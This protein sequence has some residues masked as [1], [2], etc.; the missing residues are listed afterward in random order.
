MILCGA[1]I[2]AA[3]TGKSEDRTVALGTLVLTAVWWV[4]WLSAAAATSSTTQWANS[5]R[6]AGGWDCGRSSE[7][8]NSLAANGFSYVNVYCNAYDRVPVL[9]ACCAFC[10]LTWAL[11]SGSLFFCIKEDVMGKRVLGGGAADAAPAAGTPA[12]AAPAAAPA[13]PKQVDAV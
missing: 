5:W 1:F 11:W 3:L 8:A 7:A 10:W 13:P 4:F 2:A 12:A 9:R 6:S